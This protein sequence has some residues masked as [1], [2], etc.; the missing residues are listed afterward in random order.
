MREISKVTKPFLVANLQDKK[1]DRAAY[2]D[3]QKKAV[4]KIYRVCPEGRLD[5]RKVKKLI[6]G[7]VEVY[8]YRSKR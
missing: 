4:E 6:D 8:V 3:I 2:L 1:I 5:E 7:Y